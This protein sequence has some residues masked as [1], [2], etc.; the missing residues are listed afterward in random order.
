[1]LIN[2]DLAD[3]VGYDASADGVLDFSDGPLYRGIDMAAVLEGAVSSGIERA[4]FECQTVDI[5]ERLL[6]YDMAAHEV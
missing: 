4:V 3:L 6:A 5:A 2:G 1:M